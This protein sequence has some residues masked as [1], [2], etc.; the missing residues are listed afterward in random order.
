MPKAA[1]LICHFRGRPRG[2]FSTH[3]DIEDWYDGH[4]ATVNAHTNEVETLR[5]YYYR[6]PRD[7]FNV[8]IQRFK[9]DGVRFKILNAGN[10]DFSDHEED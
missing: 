5:Y 3:Y 10:C 7:I 2:D 8:V 9:V 4:E 6:V 1:N